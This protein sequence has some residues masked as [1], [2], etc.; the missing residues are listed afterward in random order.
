MTAKRTKTK[1]T[2]PTRTKKPQPVLEEI[3]VCQFPPGQN[4]GTVLTRGTIMR[5]VKSITLLVQRAMCVTV[6]H[7]VPADVVRLSEDGPLAVLRRDAFE[8]ENRRHVMLH[9]D[10]PL[11]SDMKCAACGRC[12]TC[13]RA[14]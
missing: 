1:K 12:A 10:D 13:G 5:E 14:S 8:R 9:G 4:Q 7:E 6:L 2:P 11:P 3:L